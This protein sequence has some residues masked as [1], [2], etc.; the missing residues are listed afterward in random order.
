MQVP[1]ERYLFGRVILADALQGRAP[2]PGAHLLY[3]Y[4]YQSSVMEPDDAELRPGKLLIPPVWTNS[5][6]WK[7]GYFQTIENKEVGHFDLLQQH[8]FYMVP[9]SRSGTGKLF[10]ETGLELKH[11]SDPCGE[12]GL[13]SYRWI[14]DRVS[15]AL[16]IQRVPE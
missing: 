7:K 8:C 10:D 14:D 2:M 5:L 4:D 6:A 12:W 9:L 13:V 1:S 11:R 3:I 15:D 16:G